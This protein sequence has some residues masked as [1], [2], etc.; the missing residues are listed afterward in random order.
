MKNYIFWSVFTLLITTNLYAQTD[1]I[2]KPISPWKLT[3]TMALNFAQSSFTNW[4]AGGNNAIAT[5]ASGKF[6]LIYKKNKFLWET[7]NE[8]AYGLT[9]IEGEKRKTEDRIDLATKFGYEAFKYWNYTG[10]VTF[11]TQFDKGYASYPVTDVQK[12][13]SK[14]FAPAFLQLSLGLDYRPN[15]NFSLLISPLSSR[16][17]FVYDDY[18]SGLGAFG[19]TPGENLYSAWGALIKTTYTQKLHE[20][21]SLNTMLELFSNLLD[22]PENVAINTEINLDMKV[23]KYITS[24]INTQLIYDD[25]T[26]TIKADRSVVGPRVQFRQVLTVGIMY[27]F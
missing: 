2:K 8:L 19:V 26:K 16:F 13:N 1:T 15:D 24:R 7:Y 12:Y 5:S 6:R 4:A 9:Y 20:N 22:S 23:T 25:K 17:T 18:L 10:L 11:R 3:G 27:M 21:I 14:F